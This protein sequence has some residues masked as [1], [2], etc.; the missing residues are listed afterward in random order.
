MTANVD[1]S[2]KFSHH[3]RPIMVAMFEYLQVLAT[4][5][6]TPLTYPTRHPII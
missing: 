2:H 3:C 4:A 5:T 6:A 1:V